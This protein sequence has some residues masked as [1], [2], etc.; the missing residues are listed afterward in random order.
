[1]INYKTEQLTTDV[2]AIDDVKKDSMYLVTGE[3]RSLLID[4]CMMES[5]ILPMLKNIT[6]KDIALA[7]THAHLDHMYHADEFDEV[8]ISQKEKVS[9]KKG[10]KYIVLISGV[11]MKMSMKRFKVD[12]Y[13]GLEHKGKIDLGDREIIMMN[14]PG[15]TPGSCLYI[16]EKNRCIF[17]GDAIGSG[18]GAWMWLPYSLNLSEYIKSLTLLLQDIE[19]YKDYTFLGGHRSQG[20]KNPDQPNAVKLTYKTIEDMIKLCKMILSG[21]INHEEEEKQFFNT[22]YKYRYNSAS[23]WL[24]KNKIK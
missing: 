24:K 17:T 4:T 20:I 18:D 16:D 8:Y 19:P 10:L 6:E 7:L 21:E 13:Y 22:I 3:K 23:I 5:S 14:A 12:K 9:W 15:H 11:F 2:Y 1:M